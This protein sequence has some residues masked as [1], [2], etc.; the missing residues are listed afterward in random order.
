MNELDFGLT[1]QE[2]ELLDESS[3]MAQVSCVGGSEG[4]MG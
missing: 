2:L 4:G 3:Q 1:E